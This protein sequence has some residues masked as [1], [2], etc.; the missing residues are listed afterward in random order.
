MNRFNSLTKPLMWFMALLTVAFVAGCGGGGGS[1]GTVTSSAKSITAFSLAWTTGT[2]GSATGIINETLKTINVTVP[3]GTN[4]NP[5]YATFTTSGAS[6]TVGLVTQVNGTTP[7]DFSVPVAYKVTAADG[8]WA[9]YTVLITV[10]S[11]TAKAITTFTLAASGVPSIGTVITESATPKTIAVTMPYGT[12]DL[13]AM[14]ATFTTTGSSVKISGVTQNSGAAPTN[15]FTNSVTTPLVYTV[16]AANGTTATYNVSVT[17]ALSSSKAITSFSLAG[18]S[19]VPASTAT[20]ITGSASPFGILV[21]MPNGTTD[22]TALVATFTTTGNIVKIGSAPAVTQQSG[23]TQNDFSAASGVAPVPV[24]YRVIAVDGS[25][26]TYNVTVNVATTANPTAPTL[27]EAGR[28]VILA[29]AGVTTTGST[30][31]AISNG[32]IGITPTA[33]SGMTGFTNS[34]DPKT[35]GFVELTGLTWLGNPSL[36]YAP[37]D[38]NTVAPS[39]YTNPYPYPLKYATVTIGTPWA[40]TGA[41]LTQASTDETTAYN[42]L[43]AD[44]N[45]GAPTQVCPTELGGQTLTPGVYKTGS[46]VGITTGTLYLDAQGDPNAVWIFNI[47]GTL[48]TVGAAPNGNIVFVGGV[49]SAKNV[50]WRVAGNTSIAGSSIF[51]GNIF[52]AATIAVG[53]NA[54]IT[55]SL[56][57]GQ[58]VTASVTLIS[59]TITKP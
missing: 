55:G 57:A 34:P 5:L 3:Y 10:S 52:D 19:G 9:T 14:V 18:V 41:M 37:D 46:N 50:Y 56:F 27:G 11:S 40:T 36:S 51:I 17:V 33:R 48:T 13:T 25:T 39:G 42:F 6:V 21:T 26:A 30:A 53:A 22:L 16:T 4:V 47:S 7:N 35:G 23:I 43:A 12:T 38:S 49:G 58:S 24:A 44:P 54:N 15:D 29:Y 31:S 28:F 32:D 8:T 59:D 20:A 1:N 2:P 45:P